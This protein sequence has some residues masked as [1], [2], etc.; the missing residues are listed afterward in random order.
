[1]WPEYTNIDNEG[2]GTNYYTQYRFKFGWSRL[3]DA[4]LLGNLFSVCLLNYNRLTHRLNNRG[5][6]GR[7]VPQLLGW[8]TINNVLVPN[9][10]AVVFKKQGISQQALFHKFYLF[11]LVL[12]TMGATTAEKLKFWNRF[13]NRHACCLLGYTRPREPINERSTRIQDLAYVFS[14]IFRG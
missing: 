7:L 3:K 11:V 2:A 9:F 12:T 14:N 10:L 5:D 1:M 13:S 4:D 8:G 6:R